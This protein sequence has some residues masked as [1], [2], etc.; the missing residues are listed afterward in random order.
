MRQ[1]PALR[2]PQRL[3]CRVPTRASATIA[4]AAAAMANPA[5][6]QPVVTAFITSAAHDAQSRILLLRRSAAVRCAADAEVCACDALI[7]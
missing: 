7:T 5:P 2:P 1:C 6:P 4:H 3:A